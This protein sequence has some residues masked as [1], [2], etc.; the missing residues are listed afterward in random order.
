MAKRPRRVTGL[1]VLVGI[2]ALLAGCTQPVA[3]AGASVAVAEVQSNTETVGSGAACIPDLNTTHISL[4]APTRGG[5]TGAISSTDTAQQVREGAVPAPP[6][7][8]IVTA[9]TV[10]LHSAAAA[11]GAGVGASLGTPT[12]Y[13]Y[14]TDCAPSDVRA[15]YVA[16]LLQNQWIGSFTPASGAAGQGG[17]TTTAGSPRTSSSGANVTLFDLAA[18]TSGRFVNAH[19]NGHATAFISVLAAIQAPGTP[20]ERH[21]T[22]V[23]IIDQQATGNSRTPLLPPTVKTTPNV[24]ASAAPP[25]TPTP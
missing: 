12:I 1:A 4:I 22:Y 11:P 19:P 17:L 15:F 18:L 6:N 24:G 23:E 21:P 5:A 3:R 25:A 2:G 16:T 13:L 20:L 8:H 7:S 14:E 10:P 9:G